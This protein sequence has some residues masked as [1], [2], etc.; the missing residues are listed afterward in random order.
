MAEAA[1]DIGASDLATK[2]PTK[3]ADGAR[4]RHVVTPDLGTGGHLAQSING[5]SSPHAAMPKIGSYWNNLSKDLI[6]T[7]HLHVSFSS[8]L[9]RSR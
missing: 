2:E 3:R 6:A 4:E 9:T 7:A 8:G 5:S 1:S